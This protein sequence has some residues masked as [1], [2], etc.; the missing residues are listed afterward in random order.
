MSTHVVPL[1]L[2]EAEDKTLNPLRAAQQD[3][4]WERLVFMEDASAEQ[5]WIR[6]MLR[7]C[8]QTP[9]VRRGVASAG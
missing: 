2:T 7:P 3:V 6:A 5:Q 1:R 4:H 9:R 8:A